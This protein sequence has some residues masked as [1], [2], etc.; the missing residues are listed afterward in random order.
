MTMKQESGEVGVEVQ[1]LHEIARLRYLLHG[2][3][4]GDPD[5]E[6]EAREML[7]GAAPVDREDGVVQD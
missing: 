3:L 2:V 4:N 6:R 1:W 5:V 7:Y